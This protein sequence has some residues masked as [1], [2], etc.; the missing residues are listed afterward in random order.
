MNTMQR[1]L[2][3]LLALPCAAGSGLAQEEPDFRV[4]L[5]AMDDGVLQSPRLISAETGYNNQPLFSA[6]SHG[7]CS[8][9]MSLP[10]ALSRNADLCSSG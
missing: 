7:Y 3:L 5:V 4:W 1:I 6:D 9:A 10:Q 2:I 8:N